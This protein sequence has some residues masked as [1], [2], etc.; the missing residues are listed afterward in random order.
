MRK[1]LLFIFIIFC[2]TSVGSNKADAQVFKKLLKKA[3]NA[4]G[5]AIDKPSDKKPTS[6]VELNSQ[7]KKTQLPEDSQ[8]EQKNENL[9]TPADVKFL[10][11]SNKV[12]KPMAYQIHKGVKR[13]GLINIYRNPKSFEGQSYQS[14]SDISNK[15]VDGDNM[16]DYLLRI[17]F[18]SDYFELLDPD[19]IFKM[20]GNRSDSEIESRNKEIAQQLFLTSAFNLT[21]E[22][23]Q[24]YFFVNSD[25]PGSGSRPAQEWGGN[26][27]NEFRKRK[28]YNEFFTKYKKDLIKYGEK[29]FIDGT[30]DFY[31]VTKASLA[32]YDFN[33]KGYWVS[34]GI[35]NKGMGGGYINN[36]YGF[37]E[38]FQPTT[39]YGNNYLNK[40]VVLNRNQRRNLGLQML[41]KM[42]ESDAEKLMENKKVQQVF[43]TL[44]TKVKFKKI[45]DKGLIHPDIKFS[46]SLLDPIITFY[47]NEALTEPIGSI[48][49]ENPI[50]KAD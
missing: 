31:I 23:S 10:E 27:S 25:D 43:Y 20:Q 5:K 39:S 16:Y 26:R 24:K 37:Y 14:Y 18:L 15:L 29:I 35:N 11:P 21:S 13:T 19:S 44:K 1:K 38:D 12:F 47:T 3:E 49:L 41:L 22:E 50:I 2:F 34:I 46:Y 33:S 32:N 9:K 42:S 6:D 40:Q 48:S 17:R 45:E 8:E 4:I 36:R 30:E 7:T 28:F